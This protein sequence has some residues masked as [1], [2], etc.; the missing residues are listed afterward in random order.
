[1]QRLIGGSFYQQNEVHAT[2]SAINESIILPLQSIQFRRV[3]PEGRTGGMR[4]SRRAFC[5]LCQAERRGPNPPPLCTLSLPPRL[6]LC[7]PRLHTR[8][9]S[10]L[11]A[12]SASRRT[13]S[14]TPEL[15]SF[16]RRARRRCGHNGRIVEVDQS[17][18]LGPLLP[19]HACSYNK[20]LTNTEHL[21]RKAEAAALRKY[22]SDLR[23]D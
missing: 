11:L 4:A 19:H 8:L 7:L 13:P 15:M 6:P 12:L 14:L 3:N 21:L 16:V 23:M 18:S 9:S 22:L 10:S 2:A 20:Q 5:L 17:A 1:M